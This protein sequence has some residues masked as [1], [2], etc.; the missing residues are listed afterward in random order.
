MSGRIHLGQVNVVVRD[1]A[2]MTRFYEQLGVGLQPIPP[3]WEAHHRNTVPVDGDGD[4]AGASV[5]FDSMAFAPMWNA[6]W[7]AATPGMILIFH[8][9]T[10]DEVDEL[11]RRMV[12]A[13]HPSHQEPYDAFWGARFAA[14]AD[15][16]GNSIG[17][18]TPPD[19]TKRT[20]PPAPPS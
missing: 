11:H 7:P 19:P 20:A 5:D 16:D 13:G 9:A 4:G 10:R 18:S 3:E 15:P 6:G 14:V 8:V 12:D 1:M 17:I 2:A